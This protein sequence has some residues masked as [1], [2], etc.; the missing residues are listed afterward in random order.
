MH[1]EKRKR[2]DAEYEESRFARGNQN[3]D[4]TSDNRERRGRSSTSSSSKRT[5]KRK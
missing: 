2:S 1:E 4:T 3:G 5:D